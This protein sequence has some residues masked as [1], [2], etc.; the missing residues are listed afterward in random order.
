MYIVPDPVEVK[1][2]EDYKLSIKFKNG[3]KKIFDMKEYINQKFYKKLQDKKYFE[4][5]KVMENTMRWENGEDI[6]P[7]NLYYNSVKIEE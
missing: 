1:G 4:K 2:L 7:E 5:V 6:A 3:E